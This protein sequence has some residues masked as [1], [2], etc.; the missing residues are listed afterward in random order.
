MFF[1]TFHQI[2]FTQEE[3]KGHL[4]DGSL[5]LHTLAEWTASVPTVKLQR[6]YKTLDLTVF[7]PEWNKQVDK[8]INIH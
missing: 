4:D 5:V 8:L 2:S 1:H 3:S 7:I 6:D